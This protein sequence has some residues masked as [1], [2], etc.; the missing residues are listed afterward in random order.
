MRC[1]IAVFIAELAALVHSFPTPRTTRPSSANSATVRATKTTSATGNLHVRQRPPRRRA[2]HLNASAVAL[3]SGLDAIQTRSLKIH[4]EFIR[5]RARNSAATSGERA[6][7]RC[8][9]RAAGSATVLGAVVA[10]VRE[11]SGQV[12]GFL[13]QGWGS[14]GVYVGCVVA[15]RCS[16]AASWSAFDGPGRRV[17]PRRRA[18]RFPLLGTVGRN[19]ASLFRESRCESVEGF[20]RYVI[21]LFFLAEMRIRVD[22][23]V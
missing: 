8:V 11:G 10:A 4:T 6:E 23:G 20:C 7:A 5:L 15:G 14:A 12:L 16:R 9:F 17:A 21:F 3:S 19:G 18:A 22:C 2:R 1:D 13:G